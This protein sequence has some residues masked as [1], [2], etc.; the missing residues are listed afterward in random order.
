MKTPLEKK[1][2]ISEIE[3]R[4]D[5]DVERFSRLETGQQAVIDAPVMMELIS[6]LAVKIMPDVR[7][8]L[9]IGC[10]AGNNTIAV[11]RNK[12][13]IDC[14][15]VD[16]STAMLERARGRLESETAGDLGTYHGDFRDIDLPSSHYDI[17]IAAAV[18]H[19]LRDDADWE[20]SFGKIYD[21]LKPGGALFVSDIVTHEDESIQE[22]M[23]SR[24][25]AYLEQLGARDYRDKVFEYIDI[26]DSPRSLTYQLELMKKVGFRKTDVLHKSSCFA[27]FVGIK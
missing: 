10:G 20:K 21:L 18:L 6:N 27:A 19:H 23:W 13:G 4:F 8:M 16:L 25:G 12:P 14:D 1:S 5:V 24:Y 7:K 9:D 3:E 26:E 22:E 11:L 17:V 2:T 15:L